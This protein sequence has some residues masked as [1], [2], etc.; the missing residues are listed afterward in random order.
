MLPC[1]AVEGPGPAIGAVIGHYRIQRKLGQGGMGEVYLAEDMRLGRQVALKTLARE[2][3][4]DPDRRKR[5]LNE[6]RAAAALN[7]AGIAAVYE[8]E[9]RSEGVFIIFEY[10][11]GVTLRAL[12]QA[13]IP[14]FDELLDI[15]VQIAAALEAA[16]AKGI[17]HRDL[18]PE[19]VMRRPS[20][21]VKILDFGLARMDRGVLAAGSTTQSY[22]LT[23]AG[24]IVG[25]VGYMSP[26][27]LEGKPADHRSDIFSFGVM[28]YELATGTHPFAGETPASTIAKVMTHEPR[29]LISAN[30]LH[31]PELER[32]VRKCLRKSPDE[33]YQ[34]TRDLLVDLK[35]LKRCSREAVPTPPVPETAA[36]LVTRERRVRTPQTWWLMHTVSYLVVGTPL[37]AYLG[38]QMR[39]F[40]PPFGRFVFL[41]QVL[42]L[43]AEAWFR[44][45]GLCVWGLQR[46]E[47]GGVWERLRG[48]MLYANFGIAA[49][50]L[51]QAAMLARKDELGL[52]ALVGALAVAAII[53]A[54]FTEPAM[55]PPGK[56]E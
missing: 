23:L 55:V 12:L 16:H 21:E 53:S 48:P 13:G 33:R 18:K 32:I 39:Q 35:D 42:L 54:L 25:T 14:E 43:S 41:A 34:S 9:E 30:M 28:I 2:Y 47:L 1:P 56:P 36:A 38:W 15:T 51:A 44:I 8:L 29:P 11:E 52:A 26:E 19:N 17:V 6:A 10:V 22:S 45:V 40:A 20:G 37:L 49:T 7:H 50:I 27:Q 3:A 24:T 31:P 46:K 4:D 5:L